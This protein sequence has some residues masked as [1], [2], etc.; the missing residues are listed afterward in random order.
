MAMSHNFL[1]ILTNENRKNYFFT[2]FSTS[3]IPIWLLLRWREGGGGFCMSLI[4][5]GPTLVTLSRCMRD[6]RG[7]LSWIT[8]GVSGGL[9]VGSQVGFQGA[10]LWDHTRGLREYWCKITGGVSLGTSHDGKGHIEI[11]GELWRSACRTSCLR[12]TIG[13]RPNFIFSI[14]WI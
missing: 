8:R 7:P 10:F 11:R 3:S 1:R 12:I 13:W 6:F 5:T 4:G 9:Y 14:I 2:S